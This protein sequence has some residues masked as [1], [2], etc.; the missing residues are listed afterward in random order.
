MRQRA[1]AQRRLWHLC[2]GDS[3]PILRLPEPEPEEEELHIGRQVSEAPEAQPA[4][5]AEPEQEP[6]EFILNLID[7]QGY[8]DFSTDKPSALRISDGALVVVNCIEGDGVCDRN[9]PAAGTG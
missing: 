4:A 1:F 6:Q 2:L 7:S 3:M 5:I 8:A 9:R